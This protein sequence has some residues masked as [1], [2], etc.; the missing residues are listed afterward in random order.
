MVATTLPAVVRIVDLP[1]GTSITG[2]ELIEAV[3]TTAGVGVSVQLS[4]GQLTSLVAGL[5]TG[6]GTGQ[7]LNKTNA[8]NFSSTWSSITQ[9]VAVGTSLATTGSATSIVAFV[10]NQGISSTQIASGAIGST[11]LGALAVQRANITSAA[12]GSAQIDAGAVLRA[13]MTAFAIGSGQIDT[14]GVVSAN[15]TSSLV[16]VTPNIGTA[17][18]SSLA[19]SIG[20]VVSAGNLSV[21]WP[22]FG[23]PATTG[24]TDPNVA[25]RV[26][27]SGVVFDHGSYGTGNAWLQAR[28]GNN[29]ASNFSIVLSPNGGGVA[30]GTAGL[31]GSVVL[32]VQGTTLVTGTFG[33]VGTSLFTGSLGVVGTSVMT[34]VH[35][36]VGTTLFTSG[37]F[38]VVGTTLFTS[39]F[40]VV[41]TSLFT[42]AFGVVGT[43][44]ITGSLGVVGT[45]TLTGL[46]TV[47]GTTTLSSLATGIVVASGTGVLSS[48]GGMVLLNTLSPNNVASTNDTTSFT[49]AYRSYLFVM[50]NVAPATNS[51]IFQMQVATSGS[52]FIVGSYLSLVNVVSVNNLFSTTAFILSGQAATTLV[53][54]TSFYGITGNMYL[55]NPA[56]SANRKTISG[57]LTHIIA[58]TGVSTTTLA[59][60]NVYGIFDGNSN[61]V[62]GVN[63]SFN[64]GNI[65][66]GTIK[67][68]GL[69]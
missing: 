38:G 21:G 67:I 42:G 66:T 43:S 35:N 51:T 56:G 63:F 16:L 17:T 53:T 65:Q 62:T 1:I 5:P 64:S 31:T 46:L 34:G 14:S 8:S 12:I 30:I 33:V 18:G 41:G 2:A 58:S 59:A 61:P 3:Q 52:N 15:L 44:T 28:T 48:Q 57:M 22:N 10:A 32:G 60:C 54:N 50:D 55:Y 23:A 25:F 69:T 45:S 29:L 39:T 40:G 20:A 9:F 27:V 6:G 4:L 26:I 37:T 13:N 68:F 7:I 47:S 11:Q 19:L 24:T 36:V 49:S